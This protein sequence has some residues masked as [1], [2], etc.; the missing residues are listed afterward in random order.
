MS[1][2]WFIP[3]LVGLALT[4][5]RISTGDLQLTLN[6]AS[7]MFF[8]PEGYL[9]NVFRVTD[10]TFVWSSLIV[11]QGAHAIDR[12]RTFRSAAVLLLGVLAFYALLFG[13]FIPR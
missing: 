7:F 3:S 5:L 4:P 10:L 2:A 9:L 12:R 11:A 13:R 6:L 8:L 1:H